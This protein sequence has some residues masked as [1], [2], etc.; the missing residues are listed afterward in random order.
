ME[1]KETVFHNWLSVTGHRDDEIWDDQNDDGQNKKKSGF[2]R[3]G[4]NDQTL[5]CC[6]CCWWWWRRRRWRWQ[7][8]RE[9]AVDIMMHFRV[10][11]DWTIHVLKP[12]TQLGC[13]CNVTIQ[14]SQVTW[15]RFVSCHMQIEIFRATAILL[16]YM[17]RPSYIP[18]LDHPNNIC[19]NVQVMKFL[20]MQSS[21]ASPH[22]PPLRPKYP[23][24]YPVLK[25]LQCNS[26][27]AWH[28]LKGLFRW[29]NSGDGEILARVITVWTEEWVENSRHAMCFAADCK[30][31][32]KRYELS[33]TYSRHKQ[34]RY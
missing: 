31:H 20:I 9:L 25:S 6:C 13:P 4:L 15:Q 32:R 23:P 19:W 28:V 12:F 1:W 29:N 2:I 10:P 34:L 30:G 17:L 21:P 27:Y 33:G 11:K 7:V 22:F 14:I 3:T 16:F 8:L 18:W 24:Q 26:L 5:Q